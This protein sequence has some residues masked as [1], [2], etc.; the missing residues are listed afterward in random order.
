[1]APLYE[2]G[3]RVAWRTITKNDTEKFAEE[4]G[5]C[6]EIG[7]YSGIHTTGIVRGVVAVYLIP[8]EVVNPKVIMM[9]VI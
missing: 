5:P 7:V 1:L 9:A 2:I 3:L 4:V 6:A 8:R